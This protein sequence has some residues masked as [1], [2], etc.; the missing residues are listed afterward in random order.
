MTFPG[1]ATPRRWALG[2]LAI[3]ILSLGASELYLRH[4]GL[5][6]PALI[7]PDAAAG[8]T[9]K[10][11]QELHRFGKK[12]RINS[13]GMRSDPVPATKQANV[14]RILIVGDSFAYGSTQLDQSQT[15]AELLHH[16]LPRILHR[17]VEVFNASAGGWAIPNELGYVRSRGVF[18]ADLV[19]LALNNGDPTQP[20]QE[21]SHAGLPSVDNH[22]NF[23]LQELWERYLKGRIFPG[24]AQAVSTD[25]AA[26]DA[27]NAK[28][29]LRY[30]DQFLKITIA[31]G[32]RMAIAYIPLPAK[33][34][35][36]TGLIAWCAA[37]HVPLIDLT[38][39]A[40]QWV[41]VPDIFIVG[42]GHYNA[43]GNRL[44]ANEL[45]K[46]WPVVMPIPEASASESSK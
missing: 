18:D 20:F 2:G 22:P 43:K 37:N 41:S 6:R 13:Y 27:A 17:P 24:P 21:Y 25:T 16:E 26:S 14:F 31:G 42:G 32:S 1:S 23:A 30:L 4:L 12:T 34:E 35:P 36:A 45:E 38:S 3:V 5:G 46:D 28:Q 44:I 7:V 33:T 19:L 29:N 9:M 8:Y 11:D 39:A 15:F 40:K 10:P